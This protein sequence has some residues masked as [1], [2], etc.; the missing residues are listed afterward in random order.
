MGF[1]SAVDRPQAAIRRANR[2]DGAA[3]VSADAHRASTMDDAPAR[4]STSGRSRRPAGGPAV[5]T[6]AIPGTYASTAPTASPIRRLAPNNR[7]R[8]P[9]MRSI[10]AGRP[11]RVAVTAS[12]AA[13]HHLERVTASG[14]TPR[15]PTRSV[16]G[17]S[18]GFLRHGAETLAGETPPPTRCSAPCRM[19]PVQVVEQ[20]R[21]REIA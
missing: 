20:L 13:A 21:R 19:L 14:A 16:L 7:G 17:H 12:P 8:K 18:G 4:P 11:S 6:H 9:I 10:S 2:N 3:D 1:W 15:D 5:P